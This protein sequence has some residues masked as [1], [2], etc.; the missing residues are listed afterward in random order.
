[1]RRLISS[2]MQEAY[3]IVDGHR[4]PNLIEL[5]VIANLQFA[6]FSIPFFGSCSHSLSI[7]PIT[8]NQ[9]SICARYTGNEPDDGGLLFIIK[10][11]KVLK[12]ELLMFCYRHLAY[13]TAA[14]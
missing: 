12:L 11:A 7:T 2:V 10:I 9:D 5:F 3:L 14:V 6:S 1:M 8:R 13:L 4:T